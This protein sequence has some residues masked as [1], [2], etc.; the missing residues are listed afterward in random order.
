MDELKKTLYKDIVKTNH[1][2][3]DMISVYICGAGSWTKGLYVLSRHSDTD[4]VPARQGLMYL[5][6]SPRNNG[7][8]LSVLFIEYV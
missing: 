1:K 6:E 4:I 8:A 7:E 2:K 5:C 3:S